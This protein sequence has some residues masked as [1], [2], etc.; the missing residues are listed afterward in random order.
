MKIHLTEA[1]LQASN[2]LAFVYSWPRFSNRSGSWILQEKVTTAL[3]R[4]QQTVPLPTLQSGLCFS[5]PLDAEYV[6]KKKYLS[7]SQGEQEQE[8][9]NEDEKRERE[10]EI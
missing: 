3:P 7:H 9:E 8:T 6:K 4:L 1:S 2:R 10:N 5:P